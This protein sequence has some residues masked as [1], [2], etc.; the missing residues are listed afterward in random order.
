MCAMNDDKPGAVV[1]L[2]KRRAERR[3]YRRRTLARAIQV[4]SS[5]GISARDAETDDG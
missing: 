1:H 2:R 4:A 3:V 5:F